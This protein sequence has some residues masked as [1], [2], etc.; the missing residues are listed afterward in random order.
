LR[1]LRAYEAFV[2]ATLVYTR[3]LCARGR[4]DDPESAT[5]IAALEAEHQ[6]LRSLLAT[7]ADRVRLALPLDPAD[8]LAHAARR[9]LR[10]YR[11]A[12]CADSRRLRARSAAL[13]RRSREARTVRATPLPAVR[14]AGPGELQPRAHLPRR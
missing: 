7:G 8:R 13:V 5:D 10:L 2:N 12:V 14:P 3:Y 6:R 11:E 1:R 9:Q 4:L